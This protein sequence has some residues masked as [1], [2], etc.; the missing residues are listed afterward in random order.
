MDLNP[1]P[2][3]LGV[4]NTL[5]R[6]TLSRPKNGHRERI[7]LQLVQMLPGGGSRRVQ[8]FVPSDG[9]GRKS[10]DET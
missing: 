4:G 9:L 3:Y 6:T 2:E 1:V 7:R 8:R 10:V 5:I